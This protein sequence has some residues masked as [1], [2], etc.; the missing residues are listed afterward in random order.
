MEKE[1]DP[2]TLDRFKADITPEE[3]AALRKQKEERLKRAEEIKRKYVDPIR[4]RDKKK[5]VTNN[6]A[7]E[8]QPEPEKSILVDEN[9]PR[10][11]TTPVPEEI[12]RAGGAISHGVYRLWG[13]L[14]FHARGKETCF[15]GM[16]TLADFLGVN[17]VGVWRYLREAQEVGLIKVDRQVRRVGWGVI[18]VYT[19]KDIKRWWRERGK[20]LKKEKNGKKKGKYRNLE[21][22]MGKPFKN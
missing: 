11:W 6:C 13:A 15:P 14:K 7:E 3:T 16:K 8:K 4:Y 22:H 19:L 17:E 10:T 20:S 2:S 9:F 12:M 1:I 5:E 18:N 21:K